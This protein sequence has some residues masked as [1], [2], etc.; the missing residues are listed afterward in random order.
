MSANTGCT[1]MSL[2][3][4]NG[5]GNAHAYAADQERA[6]KLAA[7]T[8]SFA[9]P[10][11]MQPERDYNFQGEQTSVVR[12]GGQAGRRAAKWFSFDL[13]VDASHPLM[14]VVTYS[15]DEEKKRTFEIQADG[16]RVAEESVEKS[17]PSRLYDVEYKLPANIVEGKQKVTVKF[18]ATGG[19]EIAAVCGIRVVRADAER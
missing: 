11:E 5:Q 10:G 2:L 9:Q 13:P 14:L 7:A 15:S 16:Q 18:R 8:V 4:T 19:N 6:R 3:R 17:S 1:G 12:I